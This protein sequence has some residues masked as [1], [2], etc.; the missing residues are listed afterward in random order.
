MSG[1]VDGYIA[2]RKDKLAKEKQERSN[3]EA[4]EKE[5]KNHDALRNALDRYV[6]WLNADSVD[7]ESRIGMMSNPKSPVCPELELA[8]IIRRKLP[9]IRFTK[10]E[11]C[12]NES[13]TMVFLLLRCKEETSKALYSSL[14]ALLIAI[15]IGGRTLRRR[16]ETLTRSIM[17]VHLWSL[18]QSLGIPNQGLTHVR[19]TK[20]H[21]PSFLK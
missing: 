12:V 7:E 16:V 8:K 18:R 19:L 4:R 9:N 1:P 17:L 11:V 10:P 5:N 3:R 15:E 21:P 6:D 20:I 14:R 2:R 13:G